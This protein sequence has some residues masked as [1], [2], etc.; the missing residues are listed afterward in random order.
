[1]KPRTAR[2]P[3]RRVWLR[4]ADPAWRDPLDLSFA[5][6]RGGR[7]NPPASHATLYLSG[8]P[9]TARLQIERLLESSPVHVEDL[10]DAAYV[11]V[12]ATLPRTQACADAS[13]SAGLRALGL[14]DTYPRGPG[15]HPVKQSVCQAI[16]RK[17]YDVRLRGVWC[18]S[19]RA[20]DGR[21][22]EL[23]WFPATPRS[24]ARPVWTEP[25]PFGQWRYAADW[26]YIGLPN[27]PD[28]RA[29]VS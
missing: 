11:M 8:D 13:T 28:P 19:A 1:M 12:A 9:V 23:A 27:Q 20:L 18:R 29:T 25:L 4:V 16:G 7:W 2:L 3:D 17:I 5:Q 24:R 14:P 26:D 10:D 15:G 22:R 6:A 21:G